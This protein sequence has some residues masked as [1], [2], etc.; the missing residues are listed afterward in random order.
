MTLEW[1]QGGTGM[2]LGW[3][4]KGS[5]GEN[6]LEVVTEEEGWGWKRSE[7]GEDDRNDSVPALPFISGCPTSWA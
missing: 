3:L 5:E 4:Q 7:G 1:S 6:D 2:V